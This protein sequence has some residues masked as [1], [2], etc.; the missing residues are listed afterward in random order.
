MTE[1]LPD[2]PR[3]HVSPP[4]G[5]SGSS[6]AEEPQPVLVDLRAPLAILRRHLWLVL[7][8]T[9][10]VM[11]IVGYNAYT[12]TPA[13]NAVAVIRLSDPRRT[14]TGGVAESPTAVNEGRTADP[15]LSQVELLTSRTVARVVI[16][17]MPILRLHARKFPIAILS[18]IRLAPDPVGDSLQFEFR[19]DSV[20]VRGRASEVRTIY[21]TPVQLDG[22]KFIPRTKPPADRGTLRVASRERAIDHLIGRLRVTPRP[23]T[24]IFDVAYGASDPLFAQHVVNRVV[25]VFRTVNAAEAHRQSRLRREFLEQQLKVNDSLL[26]AARGALTAFR[27]RAVRAGADQQAAAQQ[28]GIDQA[29]F[30]REQLDADRRIYRGVLASLDTTGS[31]NNREALQAAVSTPGISGN[32]VVGQLFTRLVQFENARDSLAARSPT[33]PDL[34]R[35]NQQIDATEGKLLR[36]I[37]S[38]AQGLSAAFNGRIAALDELRTRREANLEQL[39]ATEAEKARLEEQ[40]ANAQKISDELRTE[41]QKARIAEAVELGQV[42]I[43]D[44]AVEPTALLGIGLYERLALGLVL[45]LV[46]GGAS[47]LL[48]EHT[49]ASIGRPKE[50]E[51]LGMPVLAAVPHCDAGRKSSSAHTLAPTVEAFRGLRLNVAHA[52]GSARPVLFAISS[53]GSRDGTSLIASNLALAFARA[54]YE[55]V[56]IDGDTRRGTL[57]T[58]LNVSRKPG[59]T[60]FLSSGATL[61]Q[62]VQTTEYRSLHFIGSGTHRPDSP[63]LLTSTGMADLFGYLRANYSVIIVDTPPLGAGVDAFALA[64]LTGHLL[65]VLRLGMTNRDLVETK[66]HLLHRLPVRVLGAALNDVRQGAECRR[67]SYYLDG[68]EATKESAEE[69][70]TVP[71]GV[72]DGAPDGVPDAVPSAER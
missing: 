35:L 36:A 59:L 23:Q 34:P 48:A 33:H 57:H 20:I 3:I 53:P 71:D 70:Q 52:Y 6:G 55:T 7:G 65:M 30:Q 22:I 69:Q 8:I 39:S 66:L 37:V 61:E 44:L 54:N 26:A 19:P 2:A 56:L 27:R 5:A 31:R 67:Y 18:D 28:A 40:V 14:L 38:A 12:A 9:G 41:H 10:A 51:E 1:Q 15:V 29:Q 13:Y 17:S 45:G 4:T 46:L 16:D 11:A 32:V 49:R 72:R 24:D 68:Y 21:G 42:E 50:V 43:V 58:L 25:E 64:A 47:A 63:E 62:I 60:D